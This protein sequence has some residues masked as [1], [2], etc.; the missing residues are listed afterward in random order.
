MAKRYYRER[1]TVRATYIV[2]CTRLIIILQRNFR[3]TAFSLVPMIHWYSSRSTSETGI[4]SIR[5]TW[6]WCTLTSERWRLWG[7][8]VPNCLSETINVTFRYITRRE[9]SF[10]IL[11]SFCWK[12]NLG[13][14][15]N[16][17]SIYLSICLSVY[18][19]RSIN[20]PLRLSFN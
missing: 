2:A 7:L 11:S 18:I 19:Y 12:K 15:S 6:L 1:L 3:Y 20:Q 5:S 8:L 17:L 9:T 16:Y 13:M 14:V 10:I 4:L